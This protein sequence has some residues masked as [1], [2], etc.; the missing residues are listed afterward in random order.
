MCL[1]SC[2][3]LQANASTADST[4]PQQLNFAEDQG[5]QQMQQRPPAAGTGGRI[6]AAA[7]TA[8]AGAGPATWLDCSLPLLAS[9][10]PAIAGTKPPRSRF[11]RAAAAPAAGKP[12]ADMNASAA[13]GQ[14]A[15]GHGDVEAAAAAAD[16]P[17][18][19]AA[20]AS[21]GFAAKEC[22]PLGS[23]ARGA[24]DTDSQADC[25]PH[26]E[27]QT[28]APTE[29]AAAAAASQPKQQEANWDL[30]QQL[31][32]DS[33]CSSLSCLPPVMAQ[34]QA[35]TTPAATPAAAA[36]A[37]QGMHSSAWQS[38]DA[39]GARE[40]TRSVGSDITGFRGFWSATPGAESQAAF[41]PAPMGHPPTGTPHQQDG[42]ARQSPYSY[43]SMQAAAGEDA[44]ADAAA[45][46][47]EGADAQAAQQRNTALMMLLSLEDSAVLGRASCA[48]A[49][50]EDAAGEAQQRHS[51]PIPE[52]EPGAEQGSPTGSEALHAAAALEAAAAEAAGIASPDAVRGGQLLRQQDWAA[53]G[54]IGQGAASSFRYTADCWPSP[55]GSPGVLL[56]SPV[57]HESD[58]MQAAS[59]APKTASRFA[60]AAAATPAK[61]LGAQQQDAA[62]GNM[63]AVSVA[64][65]IADDGSRASA[66]R[67]VQQR[68]ALEF[69]PIR[70]LTL[71][72]DASIPDAAQHLAAAAT[73][74]ADSPTWG[75]KGPHHHH[76]Q[77]Q[78]D[79]SVGAGSASSAAGIAAADQFEQLQRLLTSSS[80]SSDDWQDASP[81]CATEQQH[82]QQSPTGAH[83]QLTSL[84][85]LQM[86]TDLASSVASR[87]QERSPGLRVCVGGDGLAAPAEQLGGG[88]TGSGSPAFY[89]PADTPQTEQTAMLM[90][91]APLPSAEQQQLQPE[92][93]QEQSADGSGS[94]AHSPAASR[95][96]AAAMAP[97]GSGIP[98]GT[99]LSAQG[100]LSPLRVRTMP[101]EDA[102]ESPHGAAAKSPME[103]AAAAAAAGGS[104]AGTPVSARGRTSPLHLRASPAESVDS[105]YGAAAGEP[106]SSMAF[107]SSAARQ[108]DGDS[109]RRSISWQAFDGLGSL[110]DAEHPPT[111]G[112]V[113]CKKAW[114]PSGGSILAGSA[115]NS[116]ASSSGG[117]AANAAAAAP[118]QRRIAD[119]AAQPTGHGA[120]GPVGAQGVA[121]G[122]EGKV[123][124]AVD[125]AADLASL[126][127]LLKQQLRQ[128]ELKCT[129]QQLSVNEVS[130]VC[131]K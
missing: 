116:R 5:A 115:G 127:S 18:Q 104:S 101:G 112:S 79:D 113:A 8:Q 38:P 21:C 105:F 24:S 129:Q 122:V 33:S 96:A 43:A 25:N 11:R 3:C 2:L 54:M 55:D 125:T 97:A 89:T 9:E 85:L 124:A 86:S 83:E 10:S 72:G 40:L 47:N 36:A 52:G 28:A 44:D 57:L 37:G 48:E 98:A 76:H 60:P 17:A 111:P 117:S 78:Q 59:T 91:Q 42:C 20:E 93:Q 27:T 22:M 4:A 74:A 100:K 77:Q 80:S 12:A 118:A 58:G 35:P 92:G 70:G 84:Q 53:V 99:P 63:G 120:A 73:A 23:Y 26:P 34:Q 30:L 51:S 94:P 131:A 56:S 82:L 128:V 65:A 29:S 64:A 1:P 50:S 109:V 32:D 41:S 90:F 108:Q 75:S 45:G 19:A 71:W 6:L 114:A 126:V 61:A 103:A 123:E 69:S 46:V 68:N 110:L 102:P 39:A 16:P 130:P 81:I 121:A 31:L 62:V 49:G 119:A 106:Y 67:A 15:A 87:L 13:A 66:L 107:E 14:Q 95:T 7:V 88:G